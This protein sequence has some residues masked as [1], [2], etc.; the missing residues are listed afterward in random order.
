LADIPSLGEERKPVPVVELLVGEGLVIGV[1][2]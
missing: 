1:E 2:V